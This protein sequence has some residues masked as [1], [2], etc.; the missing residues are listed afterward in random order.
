VS[1]GVLHPPGKADHMG[2]K[3]RLSLADFGFSTV[4]GICFSLSNAFTLFPNR[5]H[6]NLK[7]RMPA[8]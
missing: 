1:L 4:M 5:F 3:A 6:A 7:M 2:S 8:N